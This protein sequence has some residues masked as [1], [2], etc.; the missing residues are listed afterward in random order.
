[1]VDPRYML[2]NKNGADEME[3]V[4]SYTS[5]DINVSNVSGQ[6]FLGNFNDII[7]N[8]NSNNQKELAEALGNGRKAITET[9]SLQ[10]EQKEELNEM[11]ERIGTE[12]IK[13]KPNKTILK[14]ISEGLR[15]SIK[16]IPDVAKAI[17]P[18]MMI[19]GKIY[20]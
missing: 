19:L 8:L 6:V 10:T 18:I 7:A 9:S 15:D 12:A 11:L 14:S 4:S 3:R 17:E 1:M 20:L 16:A 5:G 13:P 2:T